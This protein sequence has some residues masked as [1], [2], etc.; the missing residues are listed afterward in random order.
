MSFWTQLRDTVES[1]GAVVGNYFLP[2]SGLVTGQMVSSGAQD[3]LGSDVGRLAM[4]GSGVTGAGF[5]AETTG[6]PGASDLGYGWGN[7]F[8]SLGFG[9][10]GFNAPEAGFSS[11]G[12][13]GMSEQD[14]ARELGDKTVGY[15]NL[16]SPQG[17]PQFGSPWSRLM[18]SFGFG[19][20]PT[21]MGGTA[22]GGMPGW[23]K[24]SLG[25]MQLLGGLQQYQAGRAQMG[26]QED[27]ANQLAALTANPSLAM[28]TPQFQLGQ[29]AIGRQMRAGGLGTSGNINLALASG[30]GQAYTDR[31]RQLGGMAGA[32][33]AYSSPMTGMG[34]IGLGM[35]G[36]FS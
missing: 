7:M 4:L 5:G 35:Y 10:G 12:G 16:A 18:S 27:A 19:G 30:A 34:N 14:I 23:L 13:L 17:A 26:R 25:G 20:T 36:L 32:P 21:W 8:G 6:I 24:S 3:M 31:A 15:E 9:G 33:L 22:G 28:G 1:A 2:G 29:Q 11:T